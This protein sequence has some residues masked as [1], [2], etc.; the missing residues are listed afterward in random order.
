LYYFIGFSINGEFWVTEVMEASRVGKFPRLVTQGFIILI[1]KGG[2]KEDLNNWRPITL[3]N[4]AYKI[5]AKALQRCLQHMLMEIID[6][7][8]SAFTLQCYI[9]NNVLLPHETL[10]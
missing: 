8:E 9:F 10:K 6:L 1:F 3:L 5:F 7:V 2:E 4:V